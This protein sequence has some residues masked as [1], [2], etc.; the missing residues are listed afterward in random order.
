MGRTASGDREAFRLIL[1]RH[2]ARVF[3]F[4]LALLRSEDAAAD[5]TQDAFLVLLRN[6]GAYDPGRGGLGSFLLGIARN[7]VLKEFRRRKREAAEEVPADGMPGRDAPAGLELERR[8]R[9]ARLREAVASLSPAQQQV[10]TLRF[11]QELDLQGIAGLMLLPLNTV[12]S[13]LRR[14]ILSLREATGGGDDGL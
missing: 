14:A 9:A 13:H 10:L 6:P 1:E 7:L 2:E 11:Q 8:E 12:K 5:V 3:H 4:A